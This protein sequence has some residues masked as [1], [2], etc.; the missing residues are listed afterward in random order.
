VLKVP[1][2][3]VCGHSAC[4][5]MAG[6]LA[7]RAD[8]DDSLGRWLQTGLP[9]LRALHNGHAVA[10][11]EADEV[12][13]LSMVNVA[14]QAAALAGLPVVRAAVEEGRLQVMGLFFDIG[15]ARLSMLDVEQ[16]RFVPL[17]HESLDLRS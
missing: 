10:C 14:V 15:R 7:G 6:L 13:R 4:G 11:E 1:T 2:L 17:S 5:A 3:M 12:D 16:N 9:S 8:T